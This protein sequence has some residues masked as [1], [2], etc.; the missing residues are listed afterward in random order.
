MV[1]Q[2]LR[3]LIRRLARRRFAGAE[4]GV[5]MIEFALVLPVLIVLFVGLV[6]FSEAFTVNRKLAIAASTVSDLVAQEASISCA[7]LDD[8]R[9]VADEILKPYG[10]LSVTILSVIA[11]ANN[12]K[13]VA[14]SRPEGEAG[15]PYELPQAGL[16][17]PNTSVIVTEATYNFTPTIGQFLG[18]FQMQER[19]YYRPRMTASVARTGC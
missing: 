16:T 17:D 8:I 18:T 13:S 10:P 2:M 1:A 7:E 12:A 5:T 4:D 11:D 19:A 9:K 6:E 15:K 3:A 14:W